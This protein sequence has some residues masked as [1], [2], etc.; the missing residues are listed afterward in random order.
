MANRSYHDQFRID[1]DMKLREKCKELPA[2]VSTFFR[3]IEATTSART[4]MA[5]AF[6]LKIFFTY[7][8]NETG[9]GG[10]KEITQYHI[11][12]LDKVTPT[13]IQDYMDYLKVYNNEQDVECT[14]SERGLMRKLSSLRSMYK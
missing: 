2:F 12:I 6:D 14:N 8:K 7:L 11:S 4:R 13:I 9:L 10:N 1:T 3:G 5:Y